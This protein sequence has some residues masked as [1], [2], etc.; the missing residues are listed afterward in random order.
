[1]H[2]NAFINQFEKKKTWHNNLP[3]NDLLLC[4]PLLIVSRACRCGQNINI[5]IS[6]Q[7]MGGG[8]E[9]KCLPCWRS[10][11]WY[12]FWGVEVLV[13][14]IGLC[15]QYIWHHNTKFH[16]S[17]KSFSSFFVYLSYL[18]CNLFSHSKKMQFKKKIEI[19]QFANLFLPWYILRASR[20][21]KVLAPRGTRQGQVTIQHDKPKQT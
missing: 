1:M 12:N 16:Y 20:Y 10:I 21:V 7:N 9:W 14:Y 2:L 3:D 13:P 19:V 8:F 15:V 17:S 6:V 4:R 5:S 18:F 11:F